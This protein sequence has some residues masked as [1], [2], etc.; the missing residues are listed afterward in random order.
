MSG[1]VVFLLEEPSMKSLLD[2]LLPRICPGWVEREHFLCVPHEGKT[3]LDKSISRKLSAWREPDARF[4][5][6]RDSDNAECVQLKARL[7]SACQAAGRPDTM[8][9]LVCQELESWYL[10]DLAAMAAAFNEARI[11]RV[12]IRRR[13]ALPDELQKP[14]LQVRKLVRAFSK[15]AGAQAMASRMDPTVNRSHSFQVFVSGVRRLSM[16]SAA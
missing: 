12:A 14:S 2:T 11:D 5:V 9:R 16:K 10:G 8:I 15:R 6:V 7:R 13:F 1:R 3:D 4:V